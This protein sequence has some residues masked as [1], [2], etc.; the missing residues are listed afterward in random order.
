MVHFFN[1]RAT[2]GAHT[3]A[4]PGDRTKAQPNGVPVGP[5]ATHQLR[6]R[7]RGVRT[8]R[9]Q[10]HEVAG[11]LREICRT[12]CSWTV[13]AP[14]RPHHRRFRRGWHACELGEGTDT[15][16]YS[17][18]YL[19]RRPMRM[20]CGDSGVMVLDSCPRQGTT[21]TCEPP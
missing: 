17:T 3:G 5:R 20:S 16:E 19:I 9:T 2:N 1:L 7:R 12:G 4:N 10:A 14:S 6:H 11:E 18:R 8:T 21:Q 13:S 15:C